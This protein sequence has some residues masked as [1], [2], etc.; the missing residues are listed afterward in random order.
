[1]VPV[2]LDV[3]ARRRGRVVVQGLTDFLRVHDRRHTILPDTPVVAKR[4]LG[5]VLLAVALPAGVLAA[6]KPAG[7]FSVANGKGIVVIRGNGG[8]LGRVSKGSVE[9]VDL[10]PTDAWRPYVNGVARSRRTVVKGTNVTFRILGGDYRLT[11][12]GEGIS[13]SARGSGTATMTGISLLGDTGVYSTDPNADCQDTPD[14]C[15]PI[16]SLPT[17]VTYGTVDTTQPVKP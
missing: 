13:I 6:T 16:S 11:V 17:R 2:A 9:L 1:M 3:R 4:A 7:G 12:H 15:T 8:L 10:A 5:V 14:Q